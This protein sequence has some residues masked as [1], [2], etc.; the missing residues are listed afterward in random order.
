MDRAANAITL[1]VCD[2]HAFINSYPL[3]E[4]IKFCSQIRR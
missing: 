2:L 1:A 4:A 3:L